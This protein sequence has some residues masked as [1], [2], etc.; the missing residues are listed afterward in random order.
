MRQ[1]RYDIRKEDLEA[2]LEARMT[3]KAMASVYGCHAWM[4]GYRMRE[5]GL[6]RPNS[7]LPRPN[8]AMAIRDWKGR[9]AHLTSTTRN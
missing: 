5:F 3:Y 4:I 1:R 2:M 7:V 9:Y 6:T 8:V